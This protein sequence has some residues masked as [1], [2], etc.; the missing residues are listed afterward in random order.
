[1]A[2]GVCTNW[3]G[4]F[5]PSTGQNWKILQK[6]KIE[7]VTTHNAETCYVKHVLHPL[8]FFFHLIWVLGG[9]V[10]KGARAKPAYFDIVTIQI[11]QTSYIKH[12]LA[13]F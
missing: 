2:F 6:K 3:L 5:S 9:G 8:C 1:M 4:N 11:D 12:V 7:V 13:P 10:P